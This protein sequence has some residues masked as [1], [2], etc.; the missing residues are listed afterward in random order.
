MAAGVSAG[1]QKRGEGVGRNTIS[2]LPGS[3]IRRAG[4]PRES[5][6]MLVEH[7]DGEPSFWP[8]LEL[9]SLTQVTAEHHTPS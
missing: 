2:K 9:L 3:L 1:G 7:I 4:S 5:V 8:S 6:R